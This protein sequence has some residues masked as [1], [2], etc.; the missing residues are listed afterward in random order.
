MERC[1]ALDGKGKGYEREAIEAALD[2]QELVYWRCSIDIEMFA[3]IYFPHY[4][5]LAFN[6]IHNE[7]F[8]SY[9][10][11][12]RGYRRALAAPRGY[13]KSTFAVLIEPIHDLCYAQ[14][15]FI[16]FLSN[17]DP[18][19]IAKIKDVR[20]ELLTNT[21]LIDDYRIRFTTKKPAQT[22]FVVYAGDHDCMFAAYGAGAELRGVRYLHHRPSKI[23]CDDYEHS[24][25]SAKDELREKER[26]KYFQ[27]VS[28][29]GNPETNIDYVGTVL[30]QDALL[31]RLLKNPAYRGSLY[32]AVIRWAT[33]ENLWDEWRSI[34]RDIENDKRQEDA[35]DF[36]LAN[37]QALLDGTEVLWPEKEP[38]IYLMKEMEE[39]GR[40]AFMKEKQNEPLGSDD[41]IFDQI[42]YFRETAEGLKIEAN[43]IVIPWRELQ[44]AAFGVIDPATGQSKAKVGR[45]G[46]FT[47]IVWGFKDNKGRV[48]VFGDWTRRE[49]PS[50][51]MTTIFDIQETLPDGFVKFGVE[52]NL[53]RDLLLP[54]LIAERTRRE[55]E[56][57]KLVKVPFYDIIQ[58]ENK[59]KR[60]FQLEPKVTHGWIL[61][62]KTISEEAMQQLAA[63]P[64]GDH[65][66]FPDA[67][68]MLWG[69]ANNR[70][71][72]AGLSK[73]I[74]NK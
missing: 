64:L 36:Y 38:Y 58:V 42:H 68:E 51:W 47:S 16:V 2:L 25:K 8:R 1:E 49:S 56:T 15:D 32:K 21:D 23:I 59:E 7:R 31:S 39:K 10:R 55:Q 29:L 67:V 27:V 9:Q 48:Y 44:Y 12:K 45:K 53:Y 4:C 26:D 33:N 17:T 41:Q 60:I 20:T 35:E 13:A 69:L 14:E 66:D 63:F 6:E 18:Q 11:G 28:N 73:N 5:A 34:Y 19:A 22:S 72:A 62:N 54:N 61:F 71:K 30:H 3:R 57:G 40:R 50:K 37:E 70:Y 74:Y 52:T 46:D 65:D 43:G 24:E